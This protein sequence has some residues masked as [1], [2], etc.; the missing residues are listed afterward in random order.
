MFCCA[1]VI[2]VQPVLQHWPG[3]PQPPQVCGA[4]HMPQSIEAPHPSPA[5][6]QAIPSC[7]HVCG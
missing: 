5:G 2:G 1:H 4:G 7:A 3:I 6:P